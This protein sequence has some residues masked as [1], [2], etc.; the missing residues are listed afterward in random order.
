M[1]ASIIRFMFP[2]LFVLGCTSSS[3]EET[4]ELPV[5]TGTPKYETQRTLLHEMFTGSTCGPCEPAA[6]YLGE[7]FDARP[8]QHTVIKYQLG[9]DPYF[10][11]EGY[12]R[13]IGYNPDGST[14]YSLPWLQL[15]GINGHHPND[16]D[17][18]MVYDFT[19]VYTTQW[20]DQ[21]VVK[22]SGMELSV[23][24]TVVDQTVSFDIE[25]LPYALYEDMDPQPNLVLHAA[26]IEE[27]TV[28]NIG[29][30][31]QTEFHY[32]MK[33]M[34]P[35]QDGTPLAPL[36]RLEPVTL[37]LSYTF[38]GDYKADSSMNNQVDDS[39]EHT[40]EDFD[41]LQVVVFVQDSATLEVHQS[42]WTIV[43]SE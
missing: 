12:L 23:S 8:N 4:G 16:M 28:N 41:D 39:I 17:G 32:V 37:S 21:Y 9:G 40:V 18:D 10:T 20:F 30:N 15:D 5:D 42:A 7:V 38:N 24:H 25:L 26:I 11:Y 35:N 29:S 3:G 36:K 34:V 2:P 27:T 1:M 19:D 43:T 31:G 13:R 14:G 6:G 33:K 22:P